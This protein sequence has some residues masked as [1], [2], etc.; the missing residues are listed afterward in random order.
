MNKPTV[1]VVMSVFNSAP[2]LAATLDSILLQDGIDLELIAI[3]DG[4]TDNSAQILLEYAARDFRVTVL[5]Q[6]NRGLTLALITGCKIAQGDF[7]A[8]QD[9]GGDISLQGRLARQL[10]SLHL[11]PKAVMTAC[12]ARF[13]DPDGKPL[14]EVR[15]SGRE[16][17]EGLCALSRIAG[18]S[19]HGAVMFRKKA[20]D[21]VG[22]YREAFRVAQDLDLWTRLAEVGDCLATPEVFYESR[23]SHGSITHLNR[24]LQKRATEIIARC[25]KA[26]R[27]GRDDTELLEDL[28]DLPGPARG[29]L[30][31]RV[32]DAALC[33]FMG[34][35]LRTDD[36]GRAYKYFLD[37]LDS[38]PLY[39]RAWLGILRLGVTGSLRYRRMKSR[40]EVE[41]GSGLS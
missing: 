12:G 25:A 13:V 21:N 38:W 30:S 18:P 17:H 32:R 31:D 8:R 29:W 35:V 5:Q 39:P 15:Q 28:K 37:A 40:R 27:Q 4:S 2:T 9:A 33:Y 16:L 26:R 36:P 6:E 34:S 20:Y 1:S 23:I 19:Q 7:I 10:R 3:D 41:G 14:Y 22:G 11:H 24:Q